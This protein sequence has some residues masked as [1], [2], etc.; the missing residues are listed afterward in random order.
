[1]IVHFVAAAL[2][3]VAFALL[4]DVPVKY[5]PVC[6]LIGGAGFFLA[7]LLVSLGLS[8][9]ES[10][11]FATVLVMVTSRFAAVWMRCPVTVF[12]VSGIIPLVP[13]AGIYWTA[14]HLV[15]GETSSALESGFA[16]IRAAVAIVLGIVVIFELPNKFFH[17]GKRSS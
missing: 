9:T 2:G 7:E 8:A 1:M 17:F 13:G 4:F 16:A 14:Y 3:T 11:F 6:A 5:Y 10:T 15:M 12:L